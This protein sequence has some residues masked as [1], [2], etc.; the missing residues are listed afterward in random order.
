MQETG[1]VIGCF[2]PYR[3]QRNVV[4]GRF[5]MLIQHQH[6]WGVG[7]VKS[8]IVAPTLVF[9]TGTESHQRVFAVLNPA[10]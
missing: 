4:H 7:L 8:L 2:L 1:D 3:R 6:P 10:H 9:E 5:S